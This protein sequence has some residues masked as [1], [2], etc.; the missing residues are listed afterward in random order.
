MC[1]VEQ[2]AEAV[3]QT[4]GDEGTNCQECQQ[5]DQRFEGDRQDHAAVMLG[6]IEVAR[7]EQNGEQRQHDRDD[8]RGVARAGAGCVD[9]DAA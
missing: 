6:H 4:E 5:L 8:Q 7:A 2:V 3:E 9:V 1:L